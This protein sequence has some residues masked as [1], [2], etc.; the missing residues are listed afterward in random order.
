MS[1]QFSL[2]SKFNSRFSQEAIIPHPHI[3]IPQ[4]SPQKFPIAFPA[5]CQQRVV[6]VWVGFECK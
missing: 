3:V 1:K 6:V 5:E 4:Y 2:S